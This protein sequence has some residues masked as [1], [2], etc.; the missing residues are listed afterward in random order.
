MYTLY[1]NFAGVMIL[2]VIH[3]NANDTFIIVF[4]CLHIKTI[5]FGVSIPDSNS[6]VTLVLA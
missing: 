2:M 4:I 1:I 5:G 6:G 3:V